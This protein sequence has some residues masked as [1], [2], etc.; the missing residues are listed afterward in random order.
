MGRVK[1]KCLCEHC[2]EL[3]AA[4]RV[5]VATLAGIPLDETRVCVVCIKTVQF[6][7]HSQLKG[8]K[9]HG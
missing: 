7:D 6:V 4:Y 1:E 3:P 5:E 9:K 2:M 8:A